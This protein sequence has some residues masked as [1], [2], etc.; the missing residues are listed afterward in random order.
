MG[1]GSHPLS[2]RGS[3]VNSIVDLRGYRT[4][5]AWL[6]DGDGGSEMEIWFDLR[7]FHFL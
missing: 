5:L 1:I 4:I 2:R 3:F 6:G 7:R